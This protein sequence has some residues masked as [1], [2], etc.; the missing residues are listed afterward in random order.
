MVLLNV[1][2]THVQIRWGQREE[3]QPIGNGKYSELQREREGEK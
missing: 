3:C 1:L 2:V